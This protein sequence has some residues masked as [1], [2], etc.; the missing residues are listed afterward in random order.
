[1]EGFAVIFKEVQIQNYK[2][3]KDMQLQFFPGV[4]LLIGD[5]GVGK[6]SVL[7]ALAVALGGFLDG[8][9][10]VSVAYSKMIYTL[11]QSELLEPH[12]RLSI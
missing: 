1:M 9:P 7:D 4:N 5:N 6:T 11:N 12:P 2:A 10:G 3:I 8:V